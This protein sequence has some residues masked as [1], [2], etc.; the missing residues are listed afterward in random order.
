MYQAKNY[1]Y[2]LGLEGFSDKALTMHFTLYGGYVKNTNSILEKFK[3]GS[4]L[5]DSIEGAEV[6]RRL[7]WEYNGMKLHEI[8]FE[9]LSK[10]PESLDEKSEL[11]RKLVESYGSYEDWLNST[12]K[13]IA[14]MRGIGW[15]ALVKTE[16]GELL[17][18]WFEEHNT[19]ILANSKIIL[20]IDM[21]EHA[22]L[23]DYG[24]EKLKYI[25]AFIKNIDWKICEDRFKNK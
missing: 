21:L 10:T 3:S 19:G 18:L 11:G 4:L 15:T 23:I 22:F 6:K 8:Y 20:C 7:G 14:S 12:F 13:K 9:S 16:E 24:I 5:H 17:T 25:E 1:T 2:L